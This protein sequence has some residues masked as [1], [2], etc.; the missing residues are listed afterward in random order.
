MRRYKILGTASLAGI[1]TVFAVGA[2]IYLNLI[3][4]MIHFIMSVG[5]KMFLTLAI[6]ACLLSAQNSTAQSTSLIEAV[7]NNNIDEVTAFLQ[8]GADVNAYDD[9]SD[10]VLINAAMYAS[11][12][13]MELLLQHKADPGA[14]N[15]FGQ[16]PLM[17]CTNDMN[18]MKLLLRYGA[19]INDT[20]RSGNSALLI[21]CV[22]YGKYQTVKWLIDN[23]ADVTAK[24]WTKETA[25]MRAA[26]FSDTMTIALLLSKGLDIDAH[27][28][29]FS[30]L[31]YAVR[32]GN[33]DAV[34]YLVNHGAD[35]NIAD[36]DNNPPVLWAAAAGN[37]RAVRVL[38]PKTKNINSKNKRA[39]MTPL[40]WATMNEHDDPAI[41]RAFL[42]KGARVNSKADDGSTALSWAL[43]KGNTA[44]VA[45]LR[46]AGAKE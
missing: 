19:N 24:R 39:G 18:K 35:V 4:Q 41:I 27:P 34:L 9:D 6:A 40:M 25:L 43:K 21:A 13:C 2:G 29:G 3:R 44:T 8:K 38:L 15:R 45:L 36:D 37:A 26:R 17:L 46:K 42:D 33:W 30:P 11:A 7:R 12:G 5:W 1:V 14:A 16:R 31:M 28:W 20:A 10:N 23:G 22:G 32:S